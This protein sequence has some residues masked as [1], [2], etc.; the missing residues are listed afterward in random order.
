LDSVTLLTLFGK[1]LG[2]MVM[3]QSYR[4]RP[5]D[6]AFSRFDCT[7][8]AWRIVLQFMTYERATMCWPWRWRWGQNHQRWKSKRFA[9]MQT[10]LKQTGQEVAKLNSEI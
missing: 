1:T 2:L 3:V 4:C 8:S 5:D 9:Q 6:C 10:L 7:L